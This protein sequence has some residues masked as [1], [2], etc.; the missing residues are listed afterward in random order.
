MHAWA[1]K[2]P[3]TGYFVVQAGVEHGKLEKTVETILA[4][5]RKIKKAKVSAV[6]LAKA[7]SYMK[8]TMTLSLE[9]SDEIAQNAATSLI[10]L[11]RVRT[12]EEKLKAIDK[13]SAADIKRVARD[14]F[15]TEHLNL[16]VIG[17]HTKK[18]LGTSLLK[19]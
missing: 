2:Y 19:V 5:F 13:V 11:G 3:D 10:M 18:E 4:E 14:I 1:E 8:G 15:K 7:K 17:P 16:A 9:T 6:E 12:L